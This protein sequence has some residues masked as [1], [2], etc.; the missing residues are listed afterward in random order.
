MPT[1][2]GPFTRLLARRALM[3]AATVITLASLIIGWR[4]RRDAG[5]RNAEIFELRA[6]LTRLQAELVR[7]RTENSTGEGESQTA[8]A[9]EVRAIA[10]DE[11]YENALSAWIGRVRRLEVFRAKHPELAI[12]ELSLL[13]EFDWLDATKQASLETEA[14]LRKALSEL[15]RIA[16]RK[17]APGIGQALADAV[18]ANGGKL[19][20]SV[21]E[22]VPFLPPHLDPL[23]LER[24]TLNPTGQIGGLVDTSGPSTFFL[25]ENPVDALWDTTSFFQP[26]GSMG[27]RSVGRGAASAV[28]KALANYISANGTSPQHADQLDSYL[29]NR[30]LEPALRDAAFKALTNRPDR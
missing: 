19:P 10:G 6:E 27:T 14:D 5:M 25:V 21:Q 7:S 16:R 20:Q 30:S 8:R 17:S 2:K 9:A 1:P 26:S 28:E 24:F 13:N 23:I 4:A 3:T 15:R 22:L 29:D 18:E 11:I 12:R